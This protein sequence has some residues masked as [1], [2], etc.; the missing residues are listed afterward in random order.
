MKT[1]KEVIIKSVIFHM[2]EIILW[3]VF[4]QLESNILHTHS[5]HFLSEDVYK[6]FLWIIFKYKSSLD[7]NKFYCR[8]NS[9]LVN[10]R[11][12]L[13]KVI[14]ITITELIWHY[15][16]FIELGV[17]LH[18]KIG[19]TSFQELQKIDLVIKLEKKNCVLVIHVPFLESS[20]K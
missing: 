17:K 6:S 1:K 20:I 19:S 11:N 16:R 14:G 3:A 2:L 18:E 7:I 12:P 9:V 15:N 4:A 5:C 8:C 10:G 13:I